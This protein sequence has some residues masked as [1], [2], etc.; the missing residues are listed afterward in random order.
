MGSDNLVVFFDGTFKYIEQTQSILLTLTLEDQF[1]NISA[2]D[3]AN[4][5]WTLEEQLTRIKASTELLWSEITDGGK[6]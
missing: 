5:L 2:N 1:K 6:K 3:L 4:C